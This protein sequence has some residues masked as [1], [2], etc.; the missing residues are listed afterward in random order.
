MRSLLRIQLD[1][2]MEQS[3]SLQRQSRRIT[4]LILD[5]LEKPPGEKDRNRIAQLLHESDMVGSSWTVSLIKV[6]RLLDQ[7]EQARGVVLP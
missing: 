4:R 3:D 1:N 6:Q 7:M 5:E 2:E